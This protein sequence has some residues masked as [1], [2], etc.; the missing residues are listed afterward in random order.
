MKARTAYLA[1]CLALAPS[2]VPAQGNAQWKV[3]ACTIETAQL[4]GAVLTIY[5][6]EA[7]GK[8]RMLNEEYEATITAAEIRFCNKSAVCYAISRIS[9]RFSAYSPP[10]MVA[11]SCTLGAPKF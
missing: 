8:A 5:F 3:I 10:G 7:A 9:G 6:N 2:A 1:V 4:Q 11:G